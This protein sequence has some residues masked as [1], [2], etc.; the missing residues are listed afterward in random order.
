MKKKTP[1]DYAKDLYMASLCNGAV[2][3]MVDHDIINCRVR[4]FI[5]GVNWAKRRAV[6]ERALRK[7]KRR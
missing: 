6:R 4:A 1:M 5:D 2:Q 7:P 3:T